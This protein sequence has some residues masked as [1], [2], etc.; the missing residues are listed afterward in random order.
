MWVPSLRQASWRYG[1]YFDYLLRRSDIRFILESTKGRKPEIA[2]RFSAFFMVCSTDPVP[3]SDARPVLRRTKNSKGNALA[4]GAHKYPGKNRRAGLSA[5]SGPRER[6][7]R[8]AAAGSRRPR[9]PHG[10]NA[11]AA[12][13][14]CRPCVLR[15][16]H[17]AAPVQPLEIRGLLPKFNFSTGEKRPKGIAPLWPPGG[18]NKRG[19]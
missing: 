11:K 6:I 9:P 4:L 16:P 3:R 19:V 1:M 8:K 13:W 15:A 5:F 14:G 12:L 18:N 10:W 7:W 17:N 2:L